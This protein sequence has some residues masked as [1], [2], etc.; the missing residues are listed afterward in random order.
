M[1]HDKQTI[2]LD[3]TVRTFAATADEPGWENADNNDEWAGAV[4]TIRIMK[5]IRRRGKL[6]W[7]ACKTLQTS[8]SHSSIRVLRGRCSSHISSLR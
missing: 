2:G 7:R 8:T 3:Q 1:D 4:Q 5:N 6:H